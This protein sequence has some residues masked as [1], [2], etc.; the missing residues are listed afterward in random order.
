MYIP[1]NTR[2]VLKKGVIDGLHAILTLMD[3]H[4]CTTVNMQNEERIDLKIWK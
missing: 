4:L 3:G 1:S 2:I